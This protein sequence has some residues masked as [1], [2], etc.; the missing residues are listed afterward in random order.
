VK[1]KVRNHEITRDR[2]EK[3]F[4]SCDRKVC[5]LIDEADALFGKRSSR[6]A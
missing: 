2:H 5:F 4:L 1:D 3:K 6:F